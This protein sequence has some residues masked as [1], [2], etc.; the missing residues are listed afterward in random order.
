MKLKDIND[1]LIQS[2]YPVA[3]SHFNSKPSVPFICYYSSFSNNFKADDKV[4]HKVDNIQIELYTN[5]K[6]LQAENKIE[7]ILND[8]NIAYESSE[9]WIQD[10]KLFKKIYETRLI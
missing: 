1:I 7:K 9:L 10:E 2:G 6:D 5:K 3:Y 8:N 4:Y